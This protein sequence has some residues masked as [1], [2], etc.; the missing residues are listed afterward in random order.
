MKEAGTG[1]IV[2][3]SGLKHTRTGD[4][5]LGARDDLEA[6]RALPADVSPV[7]QSLVVPEPVMFASI[8]APSR[9]KIKMMDLALQALALDDPS[10]HVILNPETNQTVLAGMGDLHLEV[11]VDR[12]KTEYGVDARLGEVAI[13]YREAVVQS[14]EENR[15]NFEAESKLDAGHV[16]VSMEASIEALP[17]VSDEGDAVGNEVRMITTYS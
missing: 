11:T 10:L 16:K 3:V 15:M 9:S 13:A 2:V 5:I 12:L 1:D 14:P 17:V 8:E 6:L 7:D 4:V